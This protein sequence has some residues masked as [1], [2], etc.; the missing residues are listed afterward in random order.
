MAL[1]SFLFLSVLSVCNA[2]VCCRTV[3]WIK[4]K[5]GTEIG[6][7]SGHTVLDGDPALPRKGRQQPPHFAAYVY[8]G[9]TAA[10]LNNGLDLVM[11]PGVP[12][13]WPGRPELSCCGQK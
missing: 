5:L 4:M 11:W 7:G 8:C 3:G 1:T 9:Q 12:L 6:L 2:G 10:H 13:F